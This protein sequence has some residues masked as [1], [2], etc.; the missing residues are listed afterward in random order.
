MVDYSTGA[1]GWSDRH[2]F[3]GGGMQQPA[4][5]SNYSPF[6]LVYK[7]QGK[8]RVE[9]REYKGG[10]GRFIALRSGLAR[11][12]LSVS[13]LIIT[14]IGLGLSDC[15]AGNPPIISKVLPVATPTQAGS[16]CY[17]NTVAW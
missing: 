15:D 3:W 17:T 4:L 14:H 11:I 6:P 16:L 10:L 2:L 12:Q 8:L 13:T 7:A 1:R 9:W 5:F